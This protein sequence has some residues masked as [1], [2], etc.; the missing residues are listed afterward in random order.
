MTVRGALRPAAV[1][2]ADSASASAALRRTARAALQSKHV[3]HAL[4]NLA[5]SLTGSAQRRPTRT[6]TGFVAI[7]VPR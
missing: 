1:L 7:C 4:Q 2:R 5:D 3:P 6:R